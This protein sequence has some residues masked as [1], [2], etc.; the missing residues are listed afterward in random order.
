MELRPLDAVLIDRELVSQGKDFQLH[1]V[2][3]LEP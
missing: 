2:T 3:R 1:G